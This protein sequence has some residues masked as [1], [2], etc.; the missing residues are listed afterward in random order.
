[1]QAHREGLPD[2]CDTILQR[3]LAKSPADRFQTAEEF[4]EALGRAVGMPTTELTRVCALS[5]A[6]GEMT[7]PT[8]PSVLERFGATPV[9]RTHP[10]TQVLVVPNPA[11]SPTGSAAEAVGTSP[12]ATNAIWSVG[13]AATIALRHKHVVL[14]RVTL[15]IAAGG[16]ALLTI[17]ALRRPAVAPTTTTAVVPRAATG[18]PAASRPQRPEVPMKTPQGPE[19]PFN[20]TPPHP[21][22]RVNQSLAAPFGFEARAL[23]DSGN[24]WRERKSQIMLADGK[25]NVQAS[26]DLEVLH[27]VPYAGVTSISYSRGRDPLWNAPEGPT[28]VARP[29]G[30][31]LGIFRG[32]R[33]WVSLRTINV[34]SEFVVLRLA[35]D[36]QAR[37]AITALEGRTGRRAAL[38]VERK[39]DW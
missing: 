27:A 19:A 3:A 36:A 26:D 7:T 35:S 1:L 21:E 20:Q 18:K 25:I 10:Q 9:P 33:H 37:R 34:E 30:L 8:Q 5:I 38:V 28:V 12:A 17:V 23:V 39:D 24:R 15:A 14:S 16:L 2:W 22:V 32:E 4:R 13:N 29:S 31:D 11:V 6:D